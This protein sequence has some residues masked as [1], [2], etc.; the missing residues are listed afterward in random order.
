MSRIGFISVHTS[1]TAQP[2]TQD[3][4]GMNVTELALAKA[5]AEQGIRVDL[6]TRRSDPDSPD[7]RELSPGLRLVQLPVGPPRLL[8][9]SEHEALIEE[10]AIELAKL[11]PYR[12][13]HS[14]HWFSGLAALPVARSQGIP[15]IATFHSIA[16]DPETPLSAGERPETP[17]RLAG[18][19]RIAAEADLLLAVSNAEAETII[20]RLGA[21]PARVQVVYPGVD[22]ELF[23][24]A[25]NEQPPIQESYLLF[26]GRLEPLKG[27]DV[28]ISALASLPTAPSW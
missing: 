14:H 7:V 17:G 18:E 12:L 4:G 27:P 6:V 13:L 5:L 23:R 21:D 10:F 1:P 26:A 25:R 9:K 2:G 19:K 28:A 20:G 15:L 8:A 22:L 16:A 3:A 24:P 11:P